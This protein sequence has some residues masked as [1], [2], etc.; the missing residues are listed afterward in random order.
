MAIGFTVASKVPESP[1]QN[2]PRGTVYHI[3]C[4]CWCTSTGDLQPLSFKFKG[5]DDILVHV[6]DIMILYVENKNISGIPSREFRCR[7]IVGGLLRD[8][9]LVFYCEACRWT[10]II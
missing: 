1:V 10:M 6:K 3:A 7:A 4:K 9:K 2:E 5:D 8:F